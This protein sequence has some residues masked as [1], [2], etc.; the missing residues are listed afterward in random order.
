M[1]VVVK[2][3][4]QAD[5]GSELKDEP[6]GRVVEPATNARGG[7]TQHNVRYVLA[8]SLTGIVIAFAAV[9]IFFFAG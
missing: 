9:Y 3:P 7:V 8:W 4:P 1:V 6:P 5:Y 2:T